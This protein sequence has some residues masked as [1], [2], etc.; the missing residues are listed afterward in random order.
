MRDPRKELFKAKKKFAKEDNEKVSKPVSSGFKV[1]VR[2][3]IIFIVLF[4]SF[5]PSSG[6]FDMAT[7]Y[8]TFI[9][10]PFFIY[11]ISRLLFSLFKKSE[12]KKNLGWYII[13]LLILL[14]PLRFPLQSISINNIKYFAVKF[15]NNC[16]EKGKCSELKDLPWTNGRLFINKNKTNNYKF[17]FSHSHM[18]EVH[19]FYGGIDEELIFEYYWAYHLGKDKTK[20]IYKY[21]GKQWIKIN[22]G[23]FNE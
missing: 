21:D 10:F 13:I 8:W 6:T 12:K 20:S 4:P 17:S 3:I 15:H 18:E 2:G 16:N 22:D 1:V 7:F 14:T 9:L 23:Y 11:Y 19:R 5:L